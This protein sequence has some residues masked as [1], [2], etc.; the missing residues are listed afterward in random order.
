MTKSD[1]DLAT[2]ELLRRQTEPSL[3]AFFRAHGLGDEFEAADRSWNKDK[4]VLHAL[5]TIE[6]R[7]DGPLQ[8]LIDDARRLFGLTEVRQVPTVRAE[9]KPN[10]VVTT[11]A[12][13]GGASPRKSETG[14]NKRMIFV[15]HGHNDG[16]KETVA[17]FL[18]NLAPRAKVV[19]LHEQ[20]NQG[21]AIIEKF[22]TYAADVK[23]AVILMTADDV[24]RAEEEEELRPRARQN[25]ILELGWFIG[26]LGRDRVTILC[27]EGV[28]TPSDI[29]GVLY[30]K[31]DKGGSW[32]WGLDKDLHAAK[33]ITKIDPSK[34]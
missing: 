27:D 8:A 24:G 18:Q 33:I 15:V 34:I 10:S 23:Y 26:R 6:R 3:R 29:L 1:E 14:R 22:E 20:P 9:T 28:E 32:R 7:G 16:Q 25:V 2:Y 17:R 19:I 12:R 30:T 4:R 21:R 31:L 11:S 13:P 5:M